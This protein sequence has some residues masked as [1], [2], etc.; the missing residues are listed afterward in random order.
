MNRL[1]NLYIKMRLLFRPWI[2]S[3]DFA[4]AEKEYITII[5]AKELNGRLY[6]Q[7]EKT[8]NRKVFFGE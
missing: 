1:K 6:I 4:S 7:K 5:Y 2:I 8:I 3:W